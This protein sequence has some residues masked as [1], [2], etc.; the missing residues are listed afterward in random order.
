[1]IVD[2]DIP[3]EAREPEVVIVG[4][5]AVGL[6]LGLCLA[7]SGSR[8][9]LLEAGPAE[10]EPSYRM[11]NAGPLGDRPFRGL[12]EGRMKALGGTTRLWGGQLSEFSRADF[13][14]AL[15][16]GTTWPISFDD[17]A[18]HVAKALRFVAP[19][20]DG[21]IGDETEHLDFGPFLR[22]SRHL[23]LPNP[24]FARFFASRMRNLD[25]LIVAPNHE[26]VRLGF[27]SD[28]RAHVVAETRSGH[29]IDLSPSYVVLANGTLEIARLLL[30]AMTL[31]EN[32]PFRDNQHVGQGFLDHLHGIAGKI[33][34]PDAR[35]LRRLFEIDFS[36]KYK[37]STKI[38][39]SDKFVLDGPRANCAA[40]VIANG[41]LRQYLNETLALV[42]R[43]IQDP[44]SG[45]ASRAM[46]RVIAMASITGPVAWSYLAEKRSYNI[47]GDDILL[48]LEV[49]QL[50]TMRSR[51]FLDPHCPP[52]T[53]PIGVDWRIDGAE[54]E[55]V[56]LFCEQVRQFFSRERL[57]VVALDER[58]IA[59][60]ASFFDDCRDAYHH[61]GGAR[62]SAHS[63]DGVVDAD[64]K[65]HGT[66]NLFV[67]GAAT[68]PSGSFANPTLL[69]MAF[70]HRLADRLHDLLETRSVARSTRELAR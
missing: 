67:L 69:A 8:V 26:V 28:G 54:I 23:W 29:S 47:F 24:D 56:A 59:G 3:D 43:I 44:W 68:F 36:N 14:R 22:C 20:F 64:L 4:A 61:I 31:E 32:C 45:G 51:A 9:V 12:V 53:A 58:I 33:E 48:G 13:E 38:R 10:P 63:A 15:P 11:R 34:C 65:V 21:A 19:E 50:P 60:D 57:G 16:G 25:R 1:M 7:G 55:S 2:G 40:T 46:R 52:T 39:A 49:E 17:I 62:M 35:R 37:V 66:K 41:T 6:V 30:R 27:S 5:G 70:A 18:P 42:R